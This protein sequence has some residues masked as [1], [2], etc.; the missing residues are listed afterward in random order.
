MVTGAHYNSVPS[1]WCH[2]D[3]TDRFQ[4]EN[5]NATSVRATVLTSNSL[6]CMAPVQ[7]AGGV[8]VRLGA[9]SSGLGTPFQM[10]A[11]PSD[12]TWSRASFP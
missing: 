4:D 12:L 10:C 1:I 2:F 9:H 6:R 7:E 8:R 11:H 5:A 3:K